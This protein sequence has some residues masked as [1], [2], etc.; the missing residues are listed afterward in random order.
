MAEWARGARGK[1]PEGLD[2][3]GDRPPQPKTEK[4]VFEMVSDR[5]LLSTG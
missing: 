2:S 3:L 5:R 4:Q 1:E